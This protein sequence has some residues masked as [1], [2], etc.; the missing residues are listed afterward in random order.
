MVM[1]PCG[2]EEAERVERF[3]IGYWTGYY[4]SATAARVQRLFRC[5]HPFFGSSMVDVIICE[6]DL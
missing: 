5:E 2:R 3:N 1:R 4:D 6:A